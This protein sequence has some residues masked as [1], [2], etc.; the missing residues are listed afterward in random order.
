MLLKQ[1]GLQSY[2]K[3]SEYQKL[4]IDEKFTII[5]G[6]NNNGKTSVIDLIYKIGM[7]GYEFKKDDINIIVKQRIYDKLEFISTDESRED[8]QIYDDVSNLCEEINILFDMH[9]VCNSEYDKLLDYCISS[10]KNDFYIKVKSSYNINELV[11]VIKNK[12]FNFGYYEDSFLGSIKTTAYI[13][14]ESFESLFTIK[15]SEVK[16]LFYISKI[17]AQRKVD[18]ENIQKNYFKQII[19]KNLDKDT[20]WMYVIEKLTLSL[21]RDLVNG[22]SNNKSI[23]QIIQ[24]LIDEKLNSTRNSFSEVSG[25]QGNTLL[26]SID[27]DSNTIK[28]ILPEFILLKYYIDRESKFGMSESSQGLG[29]NNLMNLLINLENNKETMLNDDNNIHKVKIIIMEEPEAHFHPQME[30]SFIGL[31]KENIFDNIQLLLT[32]H[33]TEIVKHVKLENIRVFRSE[34]NCLQIFNLA[35]Y[36]KDNATKAEFI[37][38]FFS[39]TFAEVIFSD[40][41]ILFEGDTER[42]YLK[43]IISDTKDGNEYKYKNLKSKYISFFQVGGAYSENYVNFLKFLNIQSLIFTDV[44]YSKEIKNIEELKTPDISGHKYQSTNPIIKNR[45]SNE[46][47]TMHDLMR[48]GYFIYPDS[49]DKINIYFQSKNDGY[50]RTFEEA[51]LF[52]NIECSSVFDQ[53]SK[54]DFHSLIVNKELKGMSKPKTNC[55]IREKIDKINSK[56]DFI[57]SVL[58]SEMI[59]PDYIEKGLTWLGK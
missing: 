54:D 22:F 34:D 17:N 20:E 7:D 12:K 5:A 24:K 13:C 11:S 10:E 43:Q 41:V 29:Y 59:I 6:G 27:F 47:K 42:L 48:L 39:H 38:K 25:E 49:D 15:M 33:S 14:N 53:I 23:K 50:A 32:T 37:R 58:I 35:E 3:T 2:R 1:I 26:G 44:D 55:T 45:L 31:I 21:K 56:T 46:N 52:Q 30:K 8:N 36:V 51:I 4:D 40:K 28:D 57:F 19:I 16:S 9:L 18:D